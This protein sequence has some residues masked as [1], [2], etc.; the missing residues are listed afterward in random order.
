MSMKQTTLLL[1]ALLCLVAPGFAAADP[2]EKIFPRKID[3]GTTAEPK[4]C[5]AHQRLM[6]LISA[7]A[8]GGR[9][10]SMRA[11]ARYAGE[12][13]NGIFVQDMTLSCAW[14]MVIV[15][16]PRLRSTADDQSAYEKTCS[17]LSAGNHAEAE[18]TARQIAKRVF[19]ANAFA[20]PGSD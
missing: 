1:I 10:A 20:L 11:V 12:F 13:A 8:L 5:K 6:P 16:S 9:R 14:R 17:M 3:C 18:D 19:R 15:G 4:N 2:D 7:G